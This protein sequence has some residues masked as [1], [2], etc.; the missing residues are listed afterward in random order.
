[1][2][3][4]HAL[5]FAPALARSLDEFAAPQRVAAIR[6]LGAAGRGFEPQIARQLTQQSELVAREA[7]RALGRVASDEAAESVTRYVLRQG[8]VAALAAE[9]VI[10]QFSASATRN[11]LRSLLRQRQFVMANP[12]FILRLLQR[13]DR[14]EPAKLADVLTPL[15]SLRFRFWNRPLAHVGR[16]AAE[17]LR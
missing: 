7:L 16:R 17:L 9:E 4:D 15:K 10:W 14:F 1:M 5:T 6:A 8:T 11:S 3:C 12:Q 13:T 2:V